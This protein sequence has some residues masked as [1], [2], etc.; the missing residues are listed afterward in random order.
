[1]RNWLLLLSV[2]LLAA[3]PA[4]PSRLDVARLRYPAASGY[5]TQSTYSDCCPVAVAIADKAGE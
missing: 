5:Q 3:V 1:M 2:C 4:K